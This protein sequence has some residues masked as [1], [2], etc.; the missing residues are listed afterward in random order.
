MIPLLQSPQSSEILGNI[1]FDMLF[2]PEHRTK[3]QMYRKKPTKKFV[4]LSMKYSIH[5]KIQSMGQKMMH[6]AWGILQVTLQMCVLTP[7]MSIS[8]FLKLQDQAQPQTHTQKN[9]FN[10]QDEDS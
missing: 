1:D 2:L 6:P 4:V 5:S 8:L 7:D 9:I 10:C 3:N